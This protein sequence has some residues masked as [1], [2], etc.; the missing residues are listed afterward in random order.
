M[1]PLRDIMM[2]IVIFR[3]LIGCSVPTPIHVHTT[4][5]I[6]DKPFASA[7]LLRLCS[8]TLRELRALGAETNWPAS[9]PAE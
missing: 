9:P 7:D 4:S 5:Q 2:N 8:T 3:V 6:S 1:D